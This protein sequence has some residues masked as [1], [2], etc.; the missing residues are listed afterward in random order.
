VVAQRGLIGYAQANAPRTADPDVKEFAELIVAARRR[1][2]A[3]V[4]EIKDFARGADRDYPREPADLAQVAEEALSFLRFD[5]E[6][7]QRRLTPRIAARPLARIH[8]GKILQVLIN[9]VRNA[10]QASP[11]GGEVII[12]VD[13]ATDGGGPARPRLQVIDRGAGMSADV[14]RRLG[15]P[16]FTTKERGSGLGL[17]ISRRIVE[18]HGGRLE[19]HSRPGEG[20]EVAVLLPALDGAGV[21][22]GARGG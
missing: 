9:L 1:L 5:G 6:V 16:F 22:T 14:V 2:N 17:G 4:D 19:V 18:E 21:G 13:E 10:A 12:V 20:T 7:Q 3:L 15:E 8:R 11:P